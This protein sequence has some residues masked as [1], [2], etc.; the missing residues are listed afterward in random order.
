VRSQA[1]LTAP[2]ADVWAT[3]VSFDDYGRWNAFTREVRAEL[4]EGAEVRMKVYGLGRRPIHQVEHMHAI[5][6]ERRLCW[7]MTIGPLL[8][9]NR[10]QWLI[11]LD[12]D[13]TLYRT[14]D[15]LTGMLTPVVRTLYGRGMQAGF[16][17]VCRGL[18]GVHGGELA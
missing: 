6:V 2:P 15:V 1:V 5:V 11:P 12:A 10:S 7:G 9:A 13:H 17:A 3:L 14:D 18:V 4:R 16:D 8:V